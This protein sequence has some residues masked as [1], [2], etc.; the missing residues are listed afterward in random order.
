MS[1]MS[2]ESQGIMYVTHENE[3][4][5]PE[6]LMQVNEWVLTSIASLIAHDNVDLHAT[7]RRDITSLTPVIAGSLGTVRLDILQATA[8]MEVIYPVKYAIFSADDR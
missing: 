3:L 2:E 5:D 8:L 7:L 1:K 6:V 4:A